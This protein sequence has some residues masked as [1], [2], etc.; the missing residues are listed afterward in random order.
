MI[1]LAAMIWAPP[2]SAKYCTKKPTG[3]I[4]CR[5]M[6][7]SG[8]PYDATL[9]I[10]YAKQG[11]SA[12]VGLFIEHAMIMEGNAKIK[13][14][15]GEIQELEYVSTHRDVTPQNLLLEAAVYKISEEQLRQMGE[16]GGFIRFF[17]PSEETDELEIKF[18]AR[19]FSDID[20][21]IAETKETLG[22]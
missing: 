8:R 4:L 19:R 22:F 2:V 13:I 10:S 16:S 6:D 11:W 5:M 1:L 15:G 14:G 18:W 20:D 12:M 7:T 21:F 3:M 9:T 17:L